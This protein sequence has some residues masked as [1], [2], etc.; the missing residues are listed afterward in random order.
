MSR[1]GAVPVVRTC[2]RPVYIPCYE[3]P[4]LTRSHKG[5]RVVNSIIRSSSLSEETIKRGPVSMPLLFVGR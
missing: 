2:K 4:W 1:L 3:P 5:P